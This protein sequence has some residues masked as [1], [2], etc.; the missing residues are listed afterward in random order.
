[1]V[2]QHGDLFKPSSAAMVPT[3]MLLQQVFF[4]IDDI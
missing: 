1:V 2:P 4:N 3:I